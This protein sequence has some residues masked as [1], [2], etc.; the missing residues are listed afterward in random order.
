MKTE[1]APITENNKKRAAFLN[2]G[3]DKPIFELT[4]EEKQTLAAEILKRLSNG[5][6]L[7]KYQEEYK[8]WSDSFE[9]DSQPY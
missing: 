2:G 1:V 5:E 3:F 8:K 4:S 7:T 9:D 6:P